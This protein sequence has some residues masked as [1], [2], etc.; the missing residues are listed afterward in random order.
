M[1]RLGLLLI[2][3]AF[4]L[5]VFAQGEIDTETKILVRN[6]WSLSAS[7][8]TNGFEMDYRSGKFVSIYKKNLWDA[9]FSIIKHP[10]EYRMTNA[11]ISGYGQYCYAKTNF[12]MEFFY[13]R[14]RQR[15]LFLKHDL[16]S[17]E[18][19]MFYFGGATLALLKPIYYEV[20]Y[21]TETTKSEK[22]D[23]NNYIHQSSAVIL[24]K[25]SFSKGFD[26]I[27]AVPGAF[28][29]AGLSFEFGKRDTKLTALEAGVKFSAFLKKLELLAQKNNPQFITNLFLT[30]RFG[31]VFHVAM[32]ENMFDKE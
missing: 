1:K 17:V 7:A 19:R 8:K 16:N 25:S 31:R 30:F 28:V 10:Q 29:K 11:Y 27:T 14:G 12:C 15:S 23:P 5:N 32:L 18:F 9:G 2:A 4:V 13:S 24:G 6:E 22:F 21:D 3:S 26:E 20:W